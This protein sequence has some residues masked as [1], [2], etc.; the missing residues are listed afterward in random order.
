VLA[1]SAAPDGIQQLASQLGLQQHAPD[2]LKS[3]FA[4]Y[5]IEAIS[6]EWLRKAAA[7][8]A[9]ITI[10]YMLCLATGRLLIARQ[11]RRNA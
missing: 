8:L 3:P 11:A 4:G 2:W 1:A 9:G 5:Q 6:S 7:G 10:I